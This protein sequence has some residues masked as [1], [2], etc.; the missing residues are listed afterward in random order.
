MQYRHDLLRFAKL[1]LRD[2]ANAEDVVQETLLAALEGHDKFQQRAQLK[3]W[4][5]SIL[6]FK[7]IDAI[8]VRK[9]EWVTAPEHFENTA[10]SELPEDTF[11][12]L[13]K[14]NGHWSQEDAPSHWGNPDQNLENAQ[15]WAVFNICLENLPTQTA[16]VFMMREFLGLSTTDICNELQLSATNCSVVLHRARMLLRV[17]LNNRWFMQNGA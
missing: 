13:F 15:F 6:K 7:I 2:E 16:R 5:F 8:R 12:G 1:Q 9:K 17:C 4:L 14:P 3:T 11:D 10:M